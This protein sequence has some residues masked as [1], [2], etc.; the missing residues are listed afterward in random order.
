M[1]NQIILCMFSRC[2]RS[3]IRQLGLPEQQTQGGMKELYLEQWIRAVRKSKTEKIHFLGRDKVICI[4]NLKS[5]R[6][7][8]WEATLFLQFF[9]PCIPPYVVFPEACL[10]K[11]EGGEL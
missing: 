7:C 5:A 3:E 2:S 11:L 6:Q 4:H 10:V 1:I 9:C 8:W